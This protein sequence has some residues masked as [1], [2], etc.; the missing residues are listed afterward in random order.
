M[1]DL[2]EQFEKETQ[3]QAIYRKFGIDYHTLKY[4]KWL[5]SQLTELKAENEAWQAKC[6]R[7]KQDL[8]RVRTENERLKESMKTHG[9]DLIRDFNEVNSKNWRLI[10]ELQSLKSKMD[11]AQKVWVAKD[12]FPIDDFV[13]VYSSKRLAEADSGYECIEVLLMEVEEK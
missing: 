8:L 12:I 10:N 2:I 11:K 13:C 3:N 1:S 4:V 7:Q 6:N 5:E 9:E